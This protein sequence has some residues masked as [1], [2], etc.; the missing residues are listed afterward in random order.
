[1]LQI[2]LRYATM[3]DMEFLYDLVNEHECRKNSLYSAPVELE[4]HK[5]WMKQTLCS[6]LRRQYIFLVSSYAVGQGRLELVGDSCR[7]SYS[8]IPEYRGLGY[9]K[10]LVQ[11]LN[12]A[13]LKDF[14]DCQ[15]S[16]GEVL[17]WNVASQKIF[18][19]LGYRVDEQDHIFYYRKEIEYY[20]ISQKLIDKGGYYF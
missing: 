4:E 14:P 7:I 2:S 3:D 12:N 8:L 11:L 13:A 18:E 17:K 6:R 9:G 16:Y 1:M 10:I 5:E 20:E 15:Y 19:E